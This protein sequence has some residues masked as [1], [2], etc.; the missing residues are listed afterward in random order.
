MHGFATA[1][2]SSGAG[3]VCSI[4]GGCREP[5]LPRVQAVEVPAPLEDVHLLVDGDLRESLSRQFSTP[6]PDILCKVQ[7]AL[8]SE[9]GHFPRCHGGYSQ[10][11][12]AKRDVHHPPGALSQAEVTSPK[13]DEHM[14]VQDASWLQLPARIGLGLPLDI[15]GTDDVADNL[16]PAAACTKQ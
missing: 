3:T 7:S 12:V 15:D 14:R 5:T 9:H 6:Q 10:F 8:V 2:R 4:C 16:H 1:C 13:S 11:L